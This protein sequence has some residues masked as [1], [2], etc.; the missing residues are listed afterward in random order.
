[1]PWL[2]HPIRL[3]GHL[4][5]LEPLRESHFAGLIE[6]GADVRIWSHLPID[7]S[8]PERLLQ[9]LKTALLNRTVGSQY[10]FTII[11]KDTQRIIGATRFFDIFEEHR[12]LEIGWTWYHPE[13]W[14][15]GYNIEC[16]LLLLTY[17]FENLGANRVQ[18]K[19]RTTN[20]RSRA[21][22]EKIGAVYEGCLRADR[23]MPDGSVRDTVV[24]SVIKNEWP[25]TKAHLEKLLQSGSDKALAKHRL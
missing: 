18:L 15:K 14:G 6:S 20:E 24:Y 1:M 23:V 17:A 9:E 7:G 3:S 10:T 22:I 8:N 13:A 21:A 25:A 2:S 5:Q 19:T 11:A 16:K 4:V 12:K